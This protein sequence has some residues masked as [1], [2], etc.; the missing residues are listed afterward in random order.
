M[1][2]DW[3]AS[4]RR[5]GHPAVA[6]PFGR[7][8]CG[9]GRG[10]CE[11]LA[12]DVPRARRR[13]DTRAGVGASAC[14]TGAGA[15]GHFP[16]PRRSRR[17]A[18]ERRAPC[19]R[20]A[21]ARGGLGM[22]RGGP[23]LSTC[24]CTPAWRCA[25]P[26]S[27]VHGLVRRRVAP[28]HARSLPHGWDSDSLGLPSHPR[29][30]AGPRSCRSPPPPRGHVPRPRLITR[31][32][33]TRTGPPPG[34]QSQEP[35]GTRPRT[36]MGHGHS[37][38]LAAPP[39]RDCRHAIHGAPVGY[40]RSLL[41]CVLP[42]LQGRASPNSTPLAPWR[43]SSSCLFPLR[44]SRSDLCP[45]W[46]AARFISEALR[47]SQGSWY[48]RNRHGHLPDVRSHRPR[49]GQW[50]R[51][52]DRYLWRPGQRRAG[53][54]G[55]CGPWNNRPRAHHRRCC[56]RGSGA[57]MDLVQPCAAWPWWEQLGELT[58]SPH[59]HLVRAME[60]QRERRVRVACVQQL[61]RYCARIQGAVFSPAYIIR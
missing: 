25:W 44:R 59:S 9:R 31:R 4:H 60:S 43:R 7:G 57:G 50:I 36:R 14:I 34:V 38:R 17:C 32:L 61:C 45:E 28:L 51:G 5:G 55:T 23:G 53:G 22:W 54:C 2:H 26:C 47:L 27:R 29:Q 30:R 15:H 41:A 42:Q 46:R 56:R 13:R 18:L 20:P 6:C 16:P 35:R 21:Q 49:V 19:V 12:H 33:Q 24:S 37:A 3:G 11:P 8:W 48:S 58:R 40:E 39:P 52:C 10:R 1:D